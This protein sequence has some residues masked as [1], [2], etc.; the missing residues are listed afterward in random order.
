M[1]GKCFIISEDHCFQRHKVIKRNF[2]L[3]F[4]YSRM[5]L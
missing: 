2:I 3:L 5:F 4:N 1:T